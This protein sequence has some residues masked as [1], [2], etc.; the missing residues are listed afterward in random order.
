MQSV[1]RKISCEESFSGGWGAPWCPMLSGGSEKSLEET[2]G[3]EPLDYRKRRSLGN[4]FSNSFDKLE[5]VSWCPR[6]TIQFILGA[7]T[8]REPRLRKM[9]LIIL[10]RKFMFFTFLPS[11]SR[12]WGACESQMTWAKLVRFAPR[13]YSCSPSTARGGLASPSSLNATP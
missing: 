4:Y 10:G 1:L 8:S 3:D 11:L 6:A 9:K 13:W 12:N 5:G 2:K 7:F